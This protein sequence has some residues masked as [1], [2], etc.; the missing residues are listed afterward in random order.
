MDTDAAGHHHNTAVV[1]FVE[2]AEAAL[3]RDCGIAGY[4]GA[5]PRVRYEADFTAPLW[6]GQEV[7]TILMVERI[8]TSSLTLRFEVW[9]EEID[10]RPR[11]LAAAGRYVTVHVPAA[12]RG[13]APWPEVWIAGWR[14]CGRATPPRRVRRP[15]RARTLRRARGLRGAWMLRRAEPGL[16]A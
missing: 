9:G 13:A 11:S 15:R 16:P 12:H 7:T 4:F 2:A 14:R 10:D 1:R 8:G 6:F 3:M 5:A